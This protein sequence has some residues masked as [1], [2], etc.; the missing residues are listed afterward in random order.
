MKSLEYPER[1]LPKSESLKHF[2]SNLPESGNGKYGFREIKELFY[3]KHMNNFEIKAL[4]NIIDKSK[5]NLIDDTEWTEFYEFYLIDFQTYDSDIDF[6]LT[7]DQL[8]TAITESPKFRHIKT[9]IIE[10]DNIDLVM[11]YLDDIKINIFK[12]VQMS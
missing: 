5:D 10:N 8:K 3:D 11:H 9:Q 7:K 1:V 2:T 6:Y 12:Y 4:F